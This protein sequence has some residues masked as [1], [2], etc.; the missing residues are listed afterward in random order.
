MAD[1]DRDMFETCRIERESVVFMSKKAVE[2][3][4]SFCITLCVRLRNG[5]VAFRL[6]DPNPEAEISGALPIGFAR[7]DGAI[8]VSVFGVIRYTVAVVVE[9]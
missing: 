2:E 5:G 6:G 1:K 4:R 8:A 3:L 7:F 9:G